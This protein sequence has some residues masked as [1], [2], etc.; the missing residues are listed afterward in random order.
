[1]QM[2]TAV[3]TALRAVDPEVPPAQIR[4]MQSVVT[5]SVADRRLNMVLMGS[6]GVLALTLA[7]IG[8]YGVMAY[9]VVQRTREMGVR[10]ALGAT[11]DRVRALVVR[12]GMRLVAV[13]LAIGAAGALALSRFVS[14]LLFGVEARDLA[15]LA[16]SA[17]LLA[18]VGFVASYIPAR[19]ATRVDPMLALRAE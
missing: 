4:D 10:L 9:Q 2:V 1:M 7:A 17:C 19:R 3:R 13:G 16:A 8:I 6:F 11:P 14:H 18:V 12:D 5:A 15:T